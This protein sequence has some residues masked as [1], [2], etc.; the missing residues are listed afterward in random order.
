[1]IPEDVRVVNS[2]EIDITF[3][4]N[5]KGHV[6][7][8]GTSRMS[9]TDA[10]VITNVSEVPYENPIYMRIN[11]IGRQWI[12]RYTLALCK[13]VLAY[14]RGKYQT[15]PIP[16]SDATLNHSDLLTDARK[17]KEDLLKELNDTLDTTSRQK[18]L[19]KKAQETEWLQK[20]L[21]GVPV[22]IYIG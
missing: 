16:D 4:Q 17:E 15:V 7:L 6:V 18:Q 9:V 20:T 10:N 5:I 12:F 21:I 1:M 22:G 2:H 13:E 8:S 14:I 11:S 3:R 19:E